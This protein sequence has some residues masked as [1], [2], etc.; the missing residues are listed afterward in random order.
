M[1]SIE[2]PTPSTK[3]GQVI[4]KI[5]FVG[6]QSVGKTSIINRFIYNSFN[7]GYQVLILNILSIIFFG[8]AN[9]WD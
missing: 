1:Q 9:Y 6:D 8:K 7:G 2:I 5:V 4:I 3:S